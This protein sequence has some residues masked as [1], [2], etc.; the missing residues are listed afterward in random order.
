MAEP[1]WVHLVDPDNSE[2]ENY[3]PSDLHEIASQRLDRTREFHEDIFARLESHDSYLFG[4]FAV[5]LYDTTK[6]TVHSVGIRVI[7]NFKQFL[8]VIRTPIGLPNNIDVTDLKNISTDVDSSKI[9]SGDCIWLITANIAEKIHKILNRT[10]ERVETLDDLL[11]DENSSE[12]SA[13]KCRQEI[14]SLRNI[15]LQL[16]MITEPTLD[17]VEK[18][19]DDELDLRETVGDDIRELFPRYTEIRLIDVQESLRHAQQRCNRGQEMMRTL[20]DN[21]SSYLDR[22]QTKAGNRLTSVA[23]IML[24]PTFIVGLYGMNIDETYFPE[25]GWFNGYLLAWLVISFLTL[26]QIFVFKKIGW[27]FKG[28]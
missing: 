5:P 26:I 10:S 8:S 18:I 14:A 15:Y 20:V 28:K 1:I 23:S 22:E 2:L 11:S 12:L 21:L 17:L 3:L 6:D 9:T 25:F 19:I 16:E 27:L 7:V 24:L 4:E 13:T